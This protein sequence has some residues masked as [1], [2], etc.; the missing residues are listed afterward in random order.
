MARPV[1]SVKNVK[2]NFAN[3]LCNL[4][5]ERNVSYYKL[6]KEIGYSEGCL[7]RIRHDKAEPSLGLLLAVAKFF[8]VTTDYLLR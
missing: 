4:L 1:G 6:S 2:T 8:N 3:N 7:S 5:K